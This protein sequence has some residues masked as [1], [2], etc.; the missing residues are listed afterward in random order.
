MHHC[1]ADGPGRP[2]GKCAA[3]SS[4]T[5]RRV[6]LAA[7]SAT[8]RAGL[9]ASAMP[10][11]RVP[12]AACPPVLSAR[13]ADLSPPDVGWSPRRPRASLTGPV[14]ALA[15]RASR[16]IFRCG[17]SPWHRQLMEAPAL[18]CR[19]HDCSVAPAARPGNATA[20]EPSFVSCQAPEGRLSGSIAPP[21][22]ERT[23]KSAMR[24]FVPTGLRPWLENSTPLTGLPQQA[25][26][27]LCRPCP[28]PR[29]RAARP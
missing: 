26:T 29:L 13:A 25:V 9:S 28:S 11:R 24:V 5:R 17:R 14:Y 18:E 22:L 2:P 8:L 4:G 7:H 16:A 3:C 27:P 10:P 15:P 12:L 23:G 19:R 21:G 1:H 6:P 20:H